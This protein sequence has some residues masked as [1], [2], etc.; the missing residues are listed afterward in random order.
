MEEIRS[1]GQPPDMPGWATGLICIVVPLAGVALVVSG[2][3]SVAEASGYI[4]P[5]MVMYE[6]I[7]GRGSA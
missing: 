7:T 6:R 5:F 1:H 4:A 2:N 3:A